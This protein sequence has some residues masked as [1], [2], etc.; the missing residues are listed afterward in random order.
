MNTFF[1]EQDGYNYWVTILFL[2]SRVMKRKMSYGC[3]L[4][5]I[6]LC[7]KQRH[8]KL[9]H[10]HSTTLYSTSILWHIHERNSWIWTL[11]ESM[12][13]RLKRQKLLQNDF[14]T[15][16]SS[17]QFDQVM[18][19]S[20]VIAIRTKLILDLQDNHFHWKILVY[21]FWKYASNLALRSGNMI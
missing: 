20:F 1:N 19:I 12:N 16:M 5:V 18:K 14:I 4:R 6:T 3:T 15:K 21:K 8:Q 13:R 10:R 2:P 11:H 9:S 17:G 7:I